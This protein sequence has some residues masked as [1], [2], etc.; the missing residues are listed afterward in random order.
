MDAQCVPDDS[1]DLIIPVRGTVP[2][3]DGMQLPGGLCGSLMGK[4]SGRDSA[5]IEAHASAAVFL[6]G[7]RRSSSWMLEGLGS[8]E[9]RLVVCWRQQCLSPA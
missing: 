3:R 5:S 4:W 6:N 7:G 1:V 9:R 2:K 8:E